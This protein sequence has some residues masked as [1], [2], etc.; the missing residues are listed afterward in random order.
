MAATQ[1]ISTISDETRKRIEE[2]LRTWSD[3]D[4]EARKRFEA[5]QPKWDQALQ[6]LKDA[7]VAS[8]RLTEADFAIRINTRD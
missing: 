8:E 3:A 2:A 7:I 4:S 6:P 5:A 1:G